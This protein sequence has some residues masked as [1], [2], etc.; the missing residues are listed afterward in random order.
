MLQDTVRSEI[1]PETATAESPQDVRQP[2]YFDR[3]RCIGA[4]CED[5]CCIGWGI[6]VDRETYHRYQNLPGQQIANRPLNTLVEINPASSSPAD[7]AKL[8]VEQARCPALL[9]GLCAIQQ[10]LGEPYIPDMC[11][12]Y[13]RVLNMVGET[14]ERSLNLSCPEAAR[15]VLDDPDAMIL[16]E[17]TDDRESHRPGTLNL[18]ADDPGSQIVRARSLAIEF[19]QQRARPLWQ[20]IVTLGLAVDRIAGMDPAD[21]VIDLERCLNWFKEGSFDAALDSLKPDPQFQLE[22]IL[23]LVV[24]RLGS[25]YTSPRFLDCYKDFMHGLNWTPESTIEQLAARY[26]SSTRTHF[27]A[28]TECHPKV[29]ENYLINY[30]FRTVFPYRSKLP[31]LKSTIDSSRASVRHAFV[32][33]VVHYAIVRSILIGMAAHH[34]HNLHVNHAIQLVQSYAK[35][36]LHCTS[37]EAA[38]VEYLERTVGDPAAKIAALVMD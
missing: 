14:L 19:I 4:T 24:N 18:I 27:A 8:R 34:K 16:L 11:S 9:D 5:T 36:F 12:K 29:L 31:G 30:I 1:A 13:P 38:A 6:P 32:L 22:T 21:A 28:F 10:T 15:L 25:D 26:Q 35:A 23:E 20:R 33:V 17:R 3:F 37:F 2:A 7:Y